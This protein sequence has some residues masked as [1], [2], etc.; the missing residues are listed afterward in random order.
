MYLDAFVKKV[1]LCYIFIAKN[2]TI[3][4]DL[5]YFFVNKDN[6]KL[7]DRILLGLNKAIA[8]GKF[9]QL[10][11]HHPVTENMLLLA[12]LDKRIVF[13]LENPLLSPK[14]KAITNDNRLWLGAKK[15]TLQTNPTATNTKQ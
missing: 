4:Q 11:Y 1:Y 3:V 7:H 12:N 8:N 15:I 9:D 13:E 2:A 5:T 14:S 6:T 10:F